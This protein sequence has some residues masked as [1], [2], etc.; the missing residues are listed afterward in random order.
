M[1]KI[2]PNADK[3]KSIQSEYTKPF[4]EKKA[5][6][7][8]VRS[9]NVILCKGNAWCIVSRAILRRVSTVMNFNAQQ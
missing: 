9:Q 6:K 3:I 8:L 5:K 2:K 1:N 7:E 4:P